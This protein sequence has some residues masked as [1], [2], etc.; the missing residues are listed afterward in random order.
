MRSQM[1]S[2]SKVGTHRREPL[3]K[4]RVSKNTALAIRRVR[5]P[6]RISK[7]S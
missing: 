1:T 4:D 2:S 7:N 3:A 5:G 6:K